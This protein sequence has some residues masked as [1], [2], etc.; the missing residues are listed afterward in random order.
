MTGR[1]KP[2]AITEAAVA[3]SFFMID[4]HKYGFDLPSKVP[5]RLLIEPY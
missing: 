1:A 4:L 5:S 2:R 3:K